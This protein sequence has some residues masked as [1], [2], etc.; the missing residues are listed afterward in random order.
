MKAIMIVLTFF[1]LWLTSF[2]STSGENILALILILTIGILHGSN[3]IRLLLNLK[4]G[5]G[6]KMSKQQ[7][8]LLYIAVVLLGAIC[9]YLIP[10]V[11]LIFFVGISAYHFGE[12]HWSGKLK[13]QSIFFTGYATV[14]GLFIFALLFYFNQPE[15]AEVVYDLTGF[16][17]PTAFFAPF[18]F[19]N[20][21]LLVILSVV[22]YQKFS[23]NFV[24][25]AFYLLVFGL[26]FSIAPLILG[27]AFYFVIWH[28]L[29]SLYDQ[30]TFLYG[31]VSSGS[32]RKYLINSL[33]YWLAALFGLLVIYYFIGG[34]D[35]L[36][37]PVL[38]SFLAA[39]TF[40][41]VFVIEQI[42]RE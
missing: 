3:D 36:F 8:L 27:F 13:K 12:Q 41:H 34:E 40:P 16:Q 32:L 18:L 4:E 31:D 26:I 1:A 9:F 6:L 28:S 39:I 22:G 21:G 30:I 20:L 19:V 24:L 15:V 7:Y 23:G 29:P 35:S 42:E 10:L 14:Y 38:F 37:L 11:T 17:L 25:E 5:L 2:L 33:F